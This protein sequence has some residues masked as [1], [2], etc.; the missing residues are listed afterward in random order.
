MGSATERLAGRTT[1]LWANLYIRQR[2][3]EE[4]LD[5]QTG[6]TYSYAPEGPEESKV[7][8]E[9]KTLRMTT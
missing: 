1:G 6:E 4:A 9:K 5:E 3:D 2:A 7:S 8:A